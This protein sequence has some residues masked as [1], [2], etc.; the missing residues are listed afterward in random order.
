MKRAEAR[1]HYTNMYCPISHKTREQPHPDGN[2]KQ[3]DSQDA[4]TTD[5]ERQTWRSVDEATQRR[6]KATRDRFFGLKTRFAVQFFQFF[7]FIIIFLHTYFL[8]LQSLKH[9]IYRTIYST[10]TYNRFWPLIGHHTPTYWAPLGLYVPSLLPFRFITIFLF[11]FH[12]YFL[13]ATLF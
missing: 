11:F 12:P 7:L 5:Q 9:L 1:D 6:R 2:Q 10:L 4:H 3:P 13:S 8:Q